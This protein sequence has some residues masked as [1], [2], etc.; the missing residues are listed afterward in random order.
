MVLSGCATAAVAECT[1]DELRAGSLF[2]IPP[3][4]PAHGSWVV[5]EETYVSLHFPGAS[6]NA[7]N[8]MR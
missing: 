1:I 3:G 2:Y 8:G 6:E 7:K 4:P 5:G